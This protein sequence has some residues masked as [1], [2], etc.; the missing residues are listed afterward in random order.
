L[1][2]GGLLFVVCCL[3]FV[4]CCLLF[5]VCCL[6]FVV[7][8]LVFG[9]WR[10]GICYLLFVVCCLLFV[11]IFNLALLAPLRALRET[12]PQTTN[13]KLFPSEAN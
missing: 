4:V 11:G 13:H 5:V 1:G 9:V 3:L 6:L 7:W 12:K 2:F 10:F 8:G